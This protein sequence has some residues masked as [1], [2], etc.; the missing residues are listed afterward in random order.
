MNIKTWFAICRWSILLFLAVAAGMAFPAD[1]WF[2]SVSGVALILL[3][4]LGVFG[5]VL[6]LKLVFGK[7]YFGCPQCGTRSNV[8]GGNKH[9]MF[10]E[11]PECGILRLTYFMWGKTKVENTEQ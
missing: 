7:L 2:S 8:L 3:I 4:I 9:E 1:H 6:G 10:M 11:C 5:A